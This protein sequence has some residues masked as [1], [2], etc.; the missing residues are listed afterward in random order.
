MKKQ[1]KEIAELKEVVER[2]EVKAANPDRE[3]PF[4]ICVDLEEFG[5][6]D[7]WFLIRPSMKVKQFLRVVLQ[8]L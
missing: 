3:F 2:L 6:G 7:I 1:N 4:K 8:R 5:F